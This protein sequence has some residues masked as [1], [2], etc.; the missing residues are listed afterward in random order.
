[1]SDAPELNMPPRLTERFVA[2]RAKDD[3]KWHNPQAD[4]TVMMEYMFEH[5]AAS[6]RAKQWPE[7]VELLAGADPVEQHEFIEEECRLVHNTVHEFIRAAFDPTPEQASHAVFMQ[8]LDEVGWRDLRPE[9]KVMYLYMLGLFHLSRCWVIGRQSFALGMSPAADVRD[10][11]AA[12]GIE[13][14]MYDQNVT[15]KHEGALIVKD[16]VHYAASIGLTET[17][18][19]KIV[20]DTFM[21][22]VTGQQPANLRSL[23]KL[24]AKCCGGKCRK[25]NG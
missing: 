7:V 10:I 20:V 6:L 14:R 23:G 21:D 17:E 9:A 11:M 8:T 12:A 18:V 13:F 4:V 3:G 15:P 16:A 5:V 19:I 2:A 22:P 24:A 25:A 1:M